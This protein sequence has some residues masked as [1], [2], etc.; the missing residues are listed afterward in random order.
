MPDSSSAPLRRR[1]LFKVA[2]LG[3]VGAAG[4]PFAA[5]C[6]DIQTG[7]GST[8][9]TEGFDFLPEYK[10]WPL[11]A[12][13]D[14]VGDP[15]NHPSGFTSYPEP[16]EAVTEVPSNS[17]TYE[18]TVPFW[19]EAPSNDDPYFAALRD[20]W[21]GTTVNLRQADGNTYADTSVQ[22]LNANEY[23]DGI[24]LFS[25]MLG[26]HTNFPET[27]VNS[28][29]DLTDILKGDISGRWPL[30]AGLPTQSW[31]QSVW[32]TDASDPESA[33]LYGIP[34]TFSGG[35]GNALFTRVDLMEAAGIAMPTTVEELLEACREW[36]DDANGKWAFGG[37]DWILPQLFGLVGDEGWSWDDEQGKL[38][39]DC[40]KPEF[41]E[42]LE[43]R[44]TLWDEKLIHPDAPTG[45]LDN[46]ALQ[47]AG[48]TLFSQEN[49]V[50][51]YDYTTKV[52]DG[53]A[54]GAIVP[55]PPIGAKGRKPTL[56]ASTSV[57]GWTFLNK[58]LSKEQVEE[59]LDVA[60]W[61]SAPYGTKENELLEYGVEGEHFEYDA[62]GNPVHTEHGQKIVQAPVNLK[63]YSGKVQRFLTG[64]P[65]VVQAHF[66]FNALCQEFIVPSIFEGVRI[67]APAASKSASQ[68]L[69]DQQND[70]AFGRA[71]LSTIPDMVQTFLDNG[72]EEA[73]TFYTDIYKSLNEQ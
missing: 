36:S 52:R 32:S 60:N 56:K 67:E 35:P 30:L 47:I 55:V 15:P 66:E 48:T 28:F 14:L 69:N 37:V 50:R 45:T 29:Y 73:R 4:L 62:G 17:G 51:W 20:A 18:I 38:V 12:E 53:Q 2:G 8:Q 71:E 1:S 54:E 5:A 39:N 40:E 61:C 43:F 13:P 57:D 21:G 41:T 59:L 49:P 11:P 64:I 46:G 7:E 68:T 34:S 22:W 24:L 19:G 33:R 25:W 27:V 44:R 65:E 16:V 10:E 63:Q 9:A 72:G 23:G 31:A 3:A 26:S 42:M 6:S 58:D 70:I